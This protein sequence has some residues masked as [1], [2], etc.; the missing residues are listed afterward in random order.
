MVRSMKLSKLFITGCDSKTSWMLSW[1]KEN[2]FKHNPDAE[3][4]V[5]DFNEMSG[6]KWFKKPNA[7]VEASKLADKVVWLDTDIEVRANL[8]PI[9]NY[10]EDNKLLMAIDDP[11]TIRR[12]EKWHNSG[13]VGF[14]GKPVI[15]HHWSKECKR[16]TEDMGPLFGDQD[17][18][19]NL[20]R[21][22]M[23]RL[24]HIKDLPKQYNTLRLDLLDNT[25]PT[26]IKCM[27]WTGRAGKEKIK[28]LMSE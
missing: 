23:N 7:M 17:I 27:H 6:I 1:F 12:Q 2:F 21:I 9:F 4:K 3:L 24:V 10:I 5:F 22:G 11:W 28:E 14:Q 19:H 20:V 18:L 26:D 25:A 13:V 15:L 8:D 16:V